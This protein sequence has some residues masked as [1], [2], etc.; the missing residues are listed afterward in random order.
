MNEKIEIHYA[1]QS[2]DVKNYQVDRRFC[3]NDRTELSKK[4]ITS[5]LNSVR[6]L[7][8]KEVNT[9]H[10]VRIFEDNCTSELKDYVNQLINQTQQQNIK[11]DMVSLNGAGIADSIKSCYDW[12]LTN[13]SNLVYQIQDDYLFTEKAV[14][15]SVDM[16]YQL[17]QSYQTHPIIC[18]YI[19]PDFMRNYR[20]KSVPR[21]IELGQ[22][23]YWTQVYDTSCS[24]L[25][26][27]YQF[28]Q[29]RDLYEVFYDL[30]KKKI[31]KGN[32][33]DL[34][35]KSLNYMFTQRGV[36]G[37]TPITGLTFH[38]QGPAEQDPYID[39]RPLWDSIDIS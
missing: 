12:L 32:I 9:V 19:D 27:H 16:F 2:C 10:N 8:T 33:I 6:Y 35:N 37:V 26:S 28:S 20:G 11:I 38:M 7:S 39:W 3:T 31:I 34:E 25:T 17:Y 23:S 29:H 5:C 30:I 4:S 21:L 36:L 1:I 15:Y 13:G 14:Y 22:H 18:P 24:F